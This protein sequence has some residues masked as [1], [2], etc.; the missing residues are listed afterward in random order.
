MGSSHRWKPERGSRVKVTPSPRAA[1]DEP[2]PPPGIWYV[3]ERG[4]EPLTWW[5][6]ATDPAAKDWAARHPGD[7][8]SNCWLAPANRLVPLNGIRI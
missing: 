4:P 5:V 6:H 8:R 7:I 2:P 1:A 3:I